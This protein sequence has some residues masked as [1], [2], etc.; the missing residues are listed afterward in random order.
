MEEDTLGAKKGIGLN[1]TRRQLEI[2]YNS[3]Y[4]LENTIKDNTYFCFLEIP[5]IDK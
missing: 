3:N 5:I 2:I 1:N 4:I